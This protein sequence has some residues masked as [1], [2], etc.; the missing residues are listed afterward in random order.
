MN[1]YQ[2]LKRLGEIIA[3]LTALYGELSEELPRLEFVG[4]HAPANSELKKMPRRLYNS[5]QKRWKSLIQ[6]PRIT[7]EQV[8]AFFLSKRYQ[9]RRR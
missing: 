7:M 1:T 8:K 5:G 9:A 2:Q 4:A 3:E 6:N